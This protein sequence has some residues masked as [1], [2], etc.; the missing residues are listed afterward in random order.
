MP[1]ENKLSVKIENKH[2]IELN[3]LASSLNALSA[4][5]DSFLRK[6]GIDYT[7]NDRKL[8]VSELKQGSIIIEL[9]SSIAVASDNFNAIFG[10]FE[11]LRASFDWIL[12]KTNQAFKYSKRDFEQL[13]EFVD[14]AARDNGASIAVHV[15]NSNNVVN[16]FYIDHLQANAA[17]NI[18]AQKVEDMTEEKPKIFSKELMYW[19]NANF[20][21][22]K[23]KT[24]NK[25]IVEKIDKKPRIA[26][27]VNEDDEIKAKSYDSRFPQKNWQNLVYVV[28][29]EVLYI[30]EVPKAYRILKLYKD[31]TFDPD[32]I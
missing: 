10:F 29:I 17:Q 2:Q 15:V 23:N 28:D 32:C 30:Q 11:Y 8:C 22:S 12:G 31:E 27:F 4:Q 3:Q 6:T 7:K 21:D 18:A 24:T 14:L 25:I 19:A 9:I 20:V 5:Y 13:S 16:N 26:V 1:Y